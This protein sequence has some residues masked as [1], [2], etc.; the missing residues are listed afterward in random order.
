[1]LGDG[2]NP[3]VAADCWDWLSYWIVYFFIVNN[4]DA[5]VAV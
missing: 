1:M 3:V 2:N 4:F 5:V